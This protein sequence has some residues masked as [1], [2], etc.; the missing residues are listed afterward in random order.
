MIVNFPDK[1]EIDVTKMDIDNGKPGDCNLCPI[2]LAALRAI[3]EL[4]IEI[5]EVIVGEDP[6]SI[7][8]WR[9]VQHNYMPQPV[10]MEETY[11]LDGDKCGDFIFNFDTGVEVEPFSTV[12]HLQQG[13]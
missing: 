10:A 8:F 9:Q 12:A 13:P 11:I 3:T 5:S 6:P 4:G 7:N 1:L 2:A